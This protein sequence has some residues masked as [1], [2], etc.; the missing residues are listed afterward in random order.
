MSNPR[1]ERARR[2]GLTH[3]TA[4]AYY[5]RG[6]QAYQKGD[7]ENAVLDLS[8]AIYYDRRYAEYYATRGLFYVEYGKFAEAE[9]DLH[10][11][12][13]LNKRLWLAHF[14][15][16]VLRYKQ[17]EYEAAHQHFLQATRH[18][19][20]KPEAWFYLAVTHYLLDN[21]LEALQAIETAINGFHP[22][23]NRRGEAQRWK[24]EIE[25]AIAARAPKPM[26]ESSARR[27]RSRHTSVTETN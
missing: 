25:K 27:R 2:L 7:L 16:G 13:R 24:A 15:L 8:E 19:D 12:L 17:K 14:A 18:P 22:A 6:L 20:A 1:L 9:A 21:L 23:D 3:A 4:E 11:A 5:H 26:A 10:Y